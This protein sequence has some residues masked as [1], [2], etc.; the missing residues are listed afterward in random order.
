MVSNSFSSLRAVWSVC[1]LVLACHGSAE[2]KTWVRRVTSPIQVGRF[3][4]VRIVLVP[5]R[6][7]LVIRALTENHGMEIATLIRGGRFGCQPVIY[8]RNGRKLRYSA[9]R[10]K[11]IN[12]G[13]THLVFLDPGA[14]RKRVFVLKSYLAK[15][16]TGRYFVE[17]SRLVIRG[18]YAGGETANLAQ[19]FVVAPILRLTIR[20][21]LPPVWK[22]VGSVPRPK[23]GPRPATPA[24]PAFPRYVI[25][26]TGPI[27][28]MSMIAQAVGA[29]NLNQVRQLCYSGGHSTTP[30]YLAS[31]KEAI[32]ATR[33][34]RAVQKRFG[35]NLE[36]QISPSPDMFQHFL[37]ELNPRSLKIKGEKAS[38]GALWFDKG[39]FVPMPSFAFHF[40]RIR[41][42]WLLD[43][44]ATYSSNPPTSLASYRRNTEYCL[45]EARM[46]DSL[47][48]AASGTQFA[49][50]H[51]FNI[52]AEHRMVAQDDWFTLQSMKDNP[53]WMKDNAQWV[54]RVKMNEKAA[55]K[56]AT[57]QP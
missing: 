40:R 42:R 18:K 36:K 46:F 3:S 14:T 26:K 30:F 21:G 7:S 35:V 24:V 25:P 39:K 50:Y 10:E 49:N 55:K 48:R 57:T 22:V 9:L 23:P 33:Y 34:C 27:A 2:G 5:A 53:Q 6:N 19:K 56:K 45:R 1:L 51:E 4:G 31:A 15:L 38:V 13:Q 8:D 16:R 29:H 28:T 44:W 12:A 11:L 20:S 47:A 54:K 52:F 41:G 43:S 17:I 37:A 32:A